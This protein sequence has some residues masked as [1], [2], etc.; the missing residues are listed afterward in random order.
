MAC[1]RVNFTFLGYEVFYPEFGSSETLVHMKLHGVTLRTIVIFIVVTMRTSVNSADLCLHKTRVFTTARHA[2]I[3]Y[4]HYYVTPFPFTLKSVSCNFGQ[5][6]WF[7]STNGKPK[8]HLLLI[9]VPSRLCKL[10]L[11]N[12]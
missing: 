5:S 1:S 8:Y 7:E 3:R 9:C 2:F 6:G 11:C 10:Y 4:T 12:L